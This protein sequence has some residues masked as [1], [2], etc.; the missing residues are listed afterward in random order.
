[1][2]QQV[3]NLASLRI[4]LSF[5]GI[6]LATRF[7][8][9]FVLLLL[10]SLFH[11]PTDNVFLPL[12]TLHVKWH[13]Q[14][15]TL[16]FKKRR[17][18]WRQTTT[19]W[20]GKRRNIVDLNQ[21]QQK[22]KNL[23]VA[24]AQVVPAVPSDNPESSIPADETVWIRPSVRVTFSKWHC[25]PNASSSSFSVGRKRDFFQTASVTSALSIANPFR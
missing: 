9:V 23:C 11:S 24:V 6:C 16:L 10:Q 17:L 4:R 13:P 18:S 14:R 15:E 1:M 19:R 21:K 5:T 7:F 8:F 25:C 2:I 22:G 12:R 20:E 3:H